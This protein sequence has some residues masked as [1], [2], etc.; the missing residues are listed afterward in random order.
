MCVMMMA[1]AVNVI[2]MAVAVN[3]I[4]MGAVTMRCYC[5]LNIATLATH[6]SIFEQPSAQAAA[7]AWFTGNERRV[8][9]GEWR[10]ASG[11]WRVTCDV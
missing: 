9:C 11:V 10:V 5:E 4:M 2:M 3:V 6:M 7:A 8:A 1:E